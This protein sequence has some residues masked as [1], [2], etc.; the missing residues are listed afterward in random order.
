MRIV[1]YARKSTDS[2]DRQ[3]HSLGDQ[4][5]AMKEI[6]VREHFTVVRIFVESQSA[7][8][9]GTRPE[10]Q[11]MVAMVERG[12]AAGILTWAVNRLSRNPVD[13]GLLAYLLQTGRLELVR[14]Y[15][16]SYSPDDSSLLF[17]IEN[18]MATDYVRNLRKDVSRGMREKAERGW[19]TCKAPVGYLNDAETREIIPDPVR[20]PLVRKAWDLMLQG[21]QTIGDVH[22]QVA[23]LGLTTARR[24]RK[25]TPISVSRLHTMFRET[26]YAGELRY[27]G[28]SYV[29]RHKP[30]VSRSE[31]ELVQ[32]LLDDR[33][34]RKAPTRKRL[35][36]AGCMKCG[37]C[38]DAI[39]GEV[40]TKRYPRTGR[41]V[42]YVYYR[43]GGRKGCTKR[44]VREEDLIAAVDQRINS[45]SLTKNVAD[46]L[47]VSFAEAVERDACAIAQDSA[48]LA[49]EAGKMEARLRKLTV[50]RV[51][52]EITAR[53]LAE[54][55]SDVITELDNIRE[56]IRRTEDSV[57]RLVQTVSQKL[58]SAVR[59]GELRGTRRDPLALATAL[60]S[61]GVHVLN[62]SPFE[63][64]LDPIIEKI[65]MFE[66]LRD[67]SEQP[68]LGDHLPLNSKW[69]T[70]VAELRNLVTEELC[71]AEEQ[72]CA[73]RRRYGRYSW[74]PGD[75]NGQR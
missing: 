38:G 68:K 74:K 27:A 42:N 26:F 48:T 10:F 45:L 7:K 13:G 21:D 19:H 54:A 53:E 43:C 3:V 1:I 70:L 36:F 61:G 14:T 15:D 8:A 16:R 41:T 2:E 28:Q 67:G 49:R 39:V 33:F 62:L 46:W 4:L 30:M 64:R 57:G 32:A 65:A 51:D 5:K 34:R 6:A 55:R 63:F 69:W 75:E 66:P 11:K 52:G 24:R 44:A 60:R 31:F 58:D 37:R 23:A 40:Q 25:S 29:G 35:P 18:A 9:P 73:R 22:R 20:F 50:M 56:S 72:E 71:C 17:A 59:M 47:K 12:E